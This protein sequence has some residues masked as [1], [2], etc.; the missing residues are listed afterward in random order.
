MADRE[1]VEQFEKEIRSME[2]EAN[3]FGAVKAPFLLAVSEL[4]KQFDQCKQKGSVL[5][6]KF[7]ES[8]SEARNLRKEM[9]Y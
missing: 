2:E 6:D 5:S 4:R 9:I 7:M 1:S 8:L 3:F